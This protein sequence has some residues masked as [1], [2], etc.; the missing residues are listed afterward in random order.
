M[1]DERVLFRWRQGSWTEMHLVWAVLLLAVLSINAAAGMDWRMLAILAALAIVWRVFHSGPVTIEVTETQ[2][3]AFTRRV[4]S[5]K[6]QL[7]EIVDVEVRRL[8][9]FEALFGPRKGGGKCAYSPT[10]P[11]GVLVRLFNGDEV[12]LGCDEPEALVRVLRERMAQIAQQP[13]DS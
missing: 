3:V 9:F 8:T 13:P 10:G 5:W 1:N 4:F 7:S 11:R 12:F 6:A 2:L